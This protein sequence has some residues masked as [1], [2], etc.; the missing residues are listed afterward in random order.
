MTTSLL[1]VYALATEC[2]IHGG[3]SFPSRFCALSSMLRPSS[4]VHSIFNLINGVG[5]VG[6]NPTT[7]DAFSLNRTTTLSE[8][9]ALALL[10]PVVLNNRR[11][12]LR[13]YQYAGR[14][15]YP[16]SATNRITSL[17]PA[18]KQREVEA[19]LLPTVALPRWY[20]DGRISRF[21]PS[22]VPSRGVSRMR[23]ARLKQYRARLTRLPVRCY[24]T[25]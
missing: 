6:T 11:C 3:Q 17:D 4:G 25:T 20:G 1:S 7:T 21:R 9:P 5:G 2:H 19:K 12:R 8:Q 24:S 18:T 16:L 22:C 13:S 23:C 15:Q 14:K 10:S